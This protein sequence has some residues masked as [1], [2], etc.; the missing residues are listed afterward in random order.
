MS[1]TKKEIE[2]VFSRPWEYACGAVENLSLGFVSRTDAQQILRMFKK[3]PESACP[4]FKELHLN[5]SDGLT[6]DP[7][8]PA[9]T[10]KSKLIFNNMFGGVFNAEPLRHAPHCLTGLA[11]IPT[12][13]REMFFACKNNLSTGKCKNELMRRTLGITLFPQ[14][15]AA[16]QNTKGK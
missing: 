9:V 5:L 2:V 13:S 15:Y 4:F 11:N 10:F 12:T 16:K 3:H 8:T 14:F 1:D 7:D 6:V